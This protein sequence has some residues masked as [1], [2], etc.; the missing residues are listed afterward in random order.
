[1]TIF[2]LLVSSIILFYIFSNIDIN[3]FIISIKSIPLLILIIGILFAVVIK[4]IESIRLVVLL[5]NNRYKFSKLFSI[6]MVG[7]F[8][9]IFFPSII[10]GDALRIYYI[11]NDNFPLKQAT[12]VILFERLVGLYSIFLMGV[13]A[14][15]IG[16]NIVISEIRITLITISIIGVIILSLLYFYN[17]IFLNLLGRISNKHSSKTI[18][19]IIS[20]FKIFDF[21]RYNTLMLLNSI[22][23]SILIYSIGIIIIIIVGNA[24]GFVEV[25]ILYYFIFVPL[26][27]IITLLPISIGGFGVREGLFGLFLAP[28]DISLAESTLLSLLAYFPFLIVGLIGGLFYIFGSYSKKDIL[29][30]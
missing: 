5:K 26:V 19:K 22:F 16:K 18:K 23:L 27:T 10:G 25:N 4:F 28:L 12:N 20:F 29:L 7:G 17:S 30:T 13:I 24:L 2:K 21:S 3:E 9:N 6:N 8:F 1:M 11:K 14:A 15:I